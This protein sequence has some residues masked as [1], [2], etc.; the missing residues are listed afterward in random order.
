MKKIQIHLLRNREQA[1]APPLLPPPLSSPSLEV[2]PL[3]AA[4]GLGE[5]CKLTQRVREKPGRQTI[6]G[7]NIPSGDSMF[8]EYFHETKC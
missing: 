3:N 6:L 7:V 8:E 2:A 4:R 5:R 1:R